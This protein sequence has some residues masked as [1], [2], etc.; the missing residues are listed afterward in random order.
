MAIEKVPEDLESNKWIL[1][2]GA[3]LALVYVPVDSLLGLPKLDKGI[4][5]LGILLLSLGFYSFWKG[6]WKYPKYGQNGTWCMV[7]SG[8]CFVGYIIYALFFASPNLIHYFDILETKTRAGVV[9]AH[10]KFKEVFP[11]FGYYSG[12]DLELQKDKDVNAITITEFKVT[13][14]D[15]L[16]DDGKWTE[17]S[18][19]SSDVIAPMEFVVKLDSNV[20]DYFAVGIK[21]MAPQ[22]AH[23]YFEPIVLY[24]ETDKRGLY[25]LDVSITVKSGSKQQTVTRSSLKVYLHAMLRESQDAHINLWKAGPKDK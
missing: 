1:T 8:T 10:E 7:L 25:T 3:L 19:K 5:T 23:S 17:M 20:Q 18:P 24:F 6:G 4:A 13:V 12:L 22:I 21:K 9:A 14:K 11:V 15:F 16:A 2:L